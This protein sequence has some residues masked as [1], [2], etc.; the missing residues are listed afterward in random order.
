MEVQQSLARLIACFLLLAHPNICLLSVLLERCGEVTA[1]PEQ[2]VRLQLDH[3]TQAEGVTR[4]A[5]LDMGRLGE[6]G[7]G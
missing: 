5:E 7:H 4:P 2:I 1:S 6:L 3:Q